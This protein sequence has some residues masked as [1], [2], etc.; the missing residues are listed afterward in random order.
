MTWFGSVMNAYLFL[1]CNVDSLRRSLSNSIE[2]FGF[3]T[4][5]S[6]DNLAEEE[7]SCLC[8]LDSM[9]AFEACWAW[10]V[11]CQPF[12]AVPKLETSWRLLLRVYSIIKKYFLCR[13][14]SQICNIFQDLPD[15]L[16]MGT[17]HISLELIVVAGH[18]TSSFLHI[19]SLFVLYIKSECIS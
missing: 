8:S 7:W 1:S 19:I 17:G 5:S 2:V 14:T 12:L 18:L 16:Q 11:F 3:L 6:W 10:T 13:H 9:S 15:C 4:P